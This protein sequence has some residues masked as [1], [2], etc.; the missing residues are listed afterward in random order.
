MCK[1]HFTIVLANLMN[2]T[3]RL[4]QESRERADLAVT[5]EDERE[6]HKIILC[7]W[8]YRPDTSLPIA[9]ALKTY[10]SR[11]R[12][13]LAERLICQSMSRDTVGDAFFSR[14]LIEKLYCY[15]DVKIDVVTSDYHVKRTSEI[16]HHVF[17]CSRLI[18]VKGSESKSID[19]G[20]KNREAQ[21][22]K[23][24]RDTFRNSKPG[25]LIAIHSQLCLSHPYYNGTIH[26]KIDTLES[27]KK[28]L[29]RGN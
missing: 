16:F 6:S 29:S 13:A 17:S 28:S 3:G 22:L 4:S 23:A 20:R 25:D 27:I 2:R 18:D 5:L 8:D 21:S 26:P 7:G 1:P 11:K 15:S 14:L 19:L 12:P 10:I 9:R 24:F